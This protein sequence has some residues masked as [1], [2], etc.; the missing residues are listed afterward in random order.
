MLVAWDEM[1]SAG[2]L[3]SKAALME[4]KTGSVKNWIVADDVYCTV[5]TPPLIAEE[6]KYASTVRRSDVPD[7][8]RPP[9]TVATV[10][11]QSVIAQ[12]LPSLIR[13]GVTPP[14]V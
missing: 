4:K 7:G 1:D 11:P 13:I 2:E 8:N 3:N 6:L 12:R 5:T 9:R 14:W 10:P